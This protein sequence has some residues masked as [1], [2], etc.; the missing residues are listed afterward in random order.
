VTA[1]PVQVCRFEFTPVLGWS[2]SRYDAF[3]ACRREYFYQYYG[4]HDPDHPRAK[5]EALKNLTSIPLETGSLV[6]DAIAA[7]LRR[8]LKSEARIDAPRF[9]EFVN[10][11]IELACRAKVFFEVHYAETESVR[12]E[13]L[14]PA[15]RECLASFL[16][17]PRFEWIARRAT[18]CKEDWL[19]E[20]PGYGETRLDG[21]KMYAKVD[22]LFVVDGRAVIAD[23]KSGKR[24]A[25]KHRRQL[26]G[27][28]AWAMHHLALQA[29]AIEAVAAY[30]RPAY[31][32]VSFTP[33]EADLRQ[34]ADQIRGET[35]EMQRLCRDVE[36]N[37]PLDKGAFAMTEDLRH[38]RRC[39]FKELC[40]RA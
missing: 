31:E 18:A 15:V 2:V 32:E 23:W 10:R 8:L 33:S 40:A 9:E 5:I 4:K 1:S 17:S 13:D 24:D 30:L 14:G 21:M 35:Q 7:V 3:S 12:P 20:P 19:I 37:I 22:F 16:G 6:H 34:F 11:K 38:C 25:F 39:N 29:E 26:L 27:Y 28:S 36:S